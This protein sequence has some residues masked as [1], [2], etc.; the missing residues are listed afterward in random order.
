MLDVESSEAIEEE[1]A[2][3]KA[4]EQRVATAVAPLSG[5]TEVLSAPVS[6]VK[7]GKD[8]AE[9]RRSPLIA[10]YLDLSLYDLI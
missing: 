3:L 10:L 9:E 8:M 4:S 5:D 7:E 2:A 1:L 6:L